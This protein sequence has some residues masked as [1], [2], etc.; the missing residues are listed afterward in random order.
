M[1]KI[2]F[3]YSTRCNIRCRHCVAAGE[4]LVENKMELAT[5]CDTVKLLAQADVK[6]ISFTAGEPLLYFSDLLT[7]IELCSFFRIYTRVVT[8]SYWA[9]TKELAEEKVD[10]LKKKGLC[11]LR[12]SFSRWHQEHVPA[13]NLLYAV[14]ACKR[15]GVDYFISFVTDFSTEDDSFESFL[16]DNN[17]KYFPEP[18]IYSGRAEGFGRGSIFTDYQENRCSMNPYLAPDLTV[19]G[20]CDAGSHFTSTN[21]F[22][23]GNVR[24]STIDELF[25]ASENNALYNC[26]RNIGIST[27]ASYSGMR[28]RE[29]VKYRKCELCKI[30]FDDQKML[31]HLQ[32]AASGELQSWVR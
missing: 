10:S 19:Y 22:K 15:A 7:L 12:L 21:F 17:L 2:A 18:V 11:Q 27:I 31:N 28:A 16:C 29:I 3:G 8:N 32:E 30:L 20:C 23:L 26:I 24:T 9:T 13:Q 5:A 6:G 25:V 14:Q 1:R 4:T